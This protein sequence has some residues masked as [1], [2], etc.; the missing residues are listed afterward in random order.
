M[1]DMSTPD[2]HRAI[3]RLEGRFDS[4]DIALKTV[5]EQIVAHDTK[6]TNGQAAL[7]VLIEDKAEGLSDDINQLGVRVVELEKHENILIGGADVKARLISFSLK[8]IQWGLPA[9]GVVALIMGF[10]KG[11]AH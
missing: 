3:G 1:T 5:S 8:A 7:R 2:M 9:G 4:F 11:A 6:T 10:A